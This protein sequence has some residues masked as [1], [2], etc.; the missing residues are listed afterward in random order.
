MPGEEV[1]SAVNEI[2][3]VHVDGDELIEIVL[4]SRKDRIDSRKVPKTVD[5]LDVVLSLF[6]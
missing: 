2:S 1:A 5:G 4:G 3:K 6:L